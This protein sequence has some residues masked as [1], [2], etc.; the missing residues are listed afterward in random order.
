MAEK[1]EFQVKNA[2][3]YDVRGPARWILSHSLRYKLFVAGML[4]GKTVSIAAYSSIRMASRG[5]WTSS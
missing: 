2:Y 3:P 5:R 1:S 4:F